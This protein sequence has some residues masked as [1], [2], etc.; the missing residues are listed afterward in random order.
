MQYFGTVTIDGDTEV[1]SVALLDINGRKLF[2][3]DLNPE[4]G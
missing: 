4:R 1:M 3:T 2:G